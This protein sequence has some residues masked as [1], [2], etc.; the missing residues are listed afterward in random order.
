MTAQGGPDNDEAGGA[1]K[2]AKRLTAWLTIAGSAVALVPAL[3]SGRPASPILII[4]L[5]LLAGPAWL[6]RRRLR[7]WHGRPEAQERIVLISTL[8]L[9]G[10]AAIVM[11]VPASRDAVVHGVIGLPDD[12]AE[13]VDVGPVALASAGPVPIPGGVGSPHRPL[14]R[15]IRATIEN[16]ST[17]PKPVIAIAFSLA[18]LDHR[19]CMSLREYRY[20]IDGSVTVSTDASR[21]IDGIAVPEGTSGGAPQQALSP[22]KGTVNGVT[23][24]TMRVNLTMTHI[25]MSLAPNA[26]TNLIITLS[27]YLV[28]SLG[29]RR[30]LSIVDDSVA[31]TLT[32]A[33]GSK[34]SRKAAPDKE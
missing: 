20:T 28:A 32:M 23:C 13:I 33:D 7:R 15:S 26:T 25:E 30:S 11:I 6:L 34:L 27:D 3:I 1:D 22:A 29:D 8:V 10:I 4:L 24:D 17:A 2:P 16:R 31:M 18:A 12:R 9:Y 5:A 21:H 14:F 19:A